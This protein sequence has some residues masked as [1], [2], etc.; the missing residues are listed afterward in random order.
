MQTLF[1]ISV[2]WGWWGG[3]DTDKAEPITRKG[4][5]G[6]IIG[7]NIKRS[8][9]NRD[10]PKVEFLLAIPSNM[11]YY[12]MA[13]IVHV[14]GSSADFKGLNTFFASRSKIML[15]LPDSNTS[16]RANRIFLSNSFIS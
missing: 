12:K 13:A 10:I 7:S 4:R 15:G 6:M 5:R 14:G 16:V 3:G 1:F 9:N 8:S 2:S 11:K